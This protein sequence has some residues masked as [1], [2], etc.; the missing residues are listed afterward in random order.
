LCAEFDPA[1]LHGTIEER[2]FEGLRVRELINNWEF[3]RFDETYGSP[4]LDEVLARQLD[5]AQP[6]VVHIHNLLNL[7]YSIPR[8]AKER[9]AAVATMLHDYTWMCPSG[10][11]R[12]HVAEEH[13][14]RTVDVER[15]ARCFRQSPLQSQQ[16]FASA[17]PR[18]ARGVGKSLATSLI[19]RAPRLAEFVRSQLVAVTARAPT[20]RDIETRLEVTRAALSFVDLFVAP[21][22]SLADE[23]LRFGVPPE[24][25]RVQDYGVRAPTHHLAATRSE[26]LRVG[27]VGTIA[28]HKGLHLLA[29]AVKRL[30][31]NSVEVFVFGDAGTF[32]LYSADVRKATEGLAWRWMGG[33]SHSTIADV[34]GR[35]DVL[36]VP[37]LW[38][39]NSPM[40]I[41]E[42]FAYGRPVVGSRLG[43]T[44]ELVHHETNGLLYDA[45]SPEQ[46]AQSL[47]RL[48]NE[49]TLLERLAKGL[50]KLKTL[51]EDAAEWT[52]RY[53]NLRRK[54]P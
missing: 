48:S 41:H 2:F 37:S 36:V 21:S 51:D 34:Y 44:T 1:R 45:T 22:Q 38:S 19:R 28:P 20:A 35:F 9:G 46:L 26:T 50:P 31:Q 14:C 49:P 18:S 13:V 7:S 42:A 29:E 11:Q 33:F 25:L 5:D 39:E 12:F 15:C 27:F 40:V 53:E 30:P 3:A 4:R 52:L 24:K 43:G 10:G 17:V 47:S 6:E 23:Y 54:Q 8:L 32:P 16:S